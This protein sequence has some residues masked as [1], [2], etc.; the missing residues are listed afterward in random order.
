MVARRY[1][2]YL[3][4]H[5][6]VTLQ[7]RNERALRADIAREQKKISSEYERMLQALMNA[8]YLTAEETASLPLVL[9]IETHDLRTDRKRPLQ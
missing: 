5:T 3:K 4:E 6:Y 7:W 8:G 9:N 1:R 2:F